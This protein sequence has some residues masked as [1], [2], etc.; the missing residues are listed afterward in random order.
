MTFRPSREACNTLLLAGMLA[1]CRGEHPEDLCNGISQTCEG[2]TA[3][4]CYVSEDC[5]QCDF[6]RDIERT[7]CVVEG[8][9][10]NGT[11]WVCRDG[12]LSGRLGSFCVDASLT[13]CA[14]HR[15]DDLW[16]DGNGHTA[17][18]RETTDGPLV[19]HPDN[20]YQCY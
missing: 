2:N 3:V 8:I 6:H 17:L 4:A 16:C 7:D 20:R 1:G 18:C 5:D 19:M 14:P 15:P 12:P 11:P 13:P 9:A 10:Y